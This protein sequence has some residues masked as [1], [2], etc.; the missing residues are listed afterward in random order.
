VLAKTTF[1]SGN[2]VY[3]FVGK[4]FLEK[5]RQRKADAIMETTRNKLLN[6]DIP[7]E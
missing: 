4:P 5:R 3:Q 2:M 7:L 1:G 6:T